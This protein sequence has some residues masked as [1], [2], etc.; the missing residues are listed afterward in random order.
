MLCA[1]GD[2]VEDVVVRVNQSIRPGTDTTATIERRPGGSAASVARE[3]AR[4]GPARFIGRV[5]DDAAGVALVAGLL[6]DSVDARVQRAGRTGTIVVLVDES[7]ERT[8]FPD[9][10]ACTELDD[11]DDGWLTDVDVLHLP[12]Y[13]I[14]SEPIGATCSHLVAVVRRAGGRVSI[15]AS[16]TGVLADVGVAEASRRFA[17][18]R[19]DVLFANSDEAALLDLVDWP[20]VVVVK[21]GAAP[22]EVVVNSRRRNVPVPALVSGIDTTGA[23]DAFAGGFLA[24]WT[25]GTDVEAAATAGVASATRLLRSRAAVVS[26]S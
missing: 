16:S 13:S 12:S 3:A 8:M 2:L 14:F 26:R 25:T 24:A 21:R 5:G 11:V 17:E 22:V 4:F 19:P 18:L 20:G 15:D 1:V 7:G 9:R 6:H 23:G 10:G